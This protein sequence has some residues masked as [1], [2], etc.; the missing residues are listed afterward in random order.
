MVGLIDAIHV[1]YTTLAQSLGLRAAKGLFA[2]KGP[3]CPKAA[4]VPCGPI[5]GPEIVF[6]D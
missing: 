3:V 1:L 4:P 5:I 6:R 2:P